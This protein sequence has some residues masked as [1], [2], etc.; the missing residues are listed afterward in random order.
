MSP[1][2][3]AS[4]CCSSS[5]ATLA[6]AHHTNIQK[7]DVDQ[8]CVSSCEL[9]AKE[10]PQFE[11]IWWCESG[12]W[13]THSLKS[14]KSSPSLSDITWI[15]GASPSTDRIYHRAHGRSE[16]HH[17]S[18]ICRRSARLHYIVLQHVDE[19]SVGVQVTYMY[20]ELLGPAILQMYQA[21]SNPKSLIFF[22]ALAY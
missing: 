5:L 20:L 14:L 1:T 4:N 8:P 6:Y 9:I 16:F 15:K 17:K 21:K 3:R 2:L 13:G 18:K 10:T 11:T 19:H 12:C 7:I 22:K